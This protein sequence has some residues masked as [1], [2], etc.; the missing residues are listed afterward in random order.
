MTELKL[1]IALQDPEFEDKVKEAVPAMTPEI[2]NLA[3]DT[4]LILLA[5]SPK[6]DPKLKYRKTSQ[7]G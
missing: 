5:R 1:T 6:D 3:R 7:R 4:E 2:Y